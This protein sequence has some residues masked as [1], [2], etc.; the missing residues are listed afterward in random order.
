MN[1]LRAIG[2]GVWEFVVGDDWVTALGVAAA[3]ALT[4]VVAT[5]G[6]AWFVTP[7]AMTVLLAFSV[8]RAARPP[9]SRPSA[10]LRPR[11]SPG[12]L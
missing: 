4:A 7:V 6:P 9:A 3:L 8:W 2:H 12:R 1:R 10:A 11:R 5:V